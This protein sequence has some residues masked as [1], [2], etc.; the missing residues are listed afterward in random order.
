MSATGPITA[1]S[2]PTVGRLSAIGV[3]PAWDAQ[4]R[5]GRRHPAALL[6]L[7]R[8]PRSCRALIPDLTGGL[9]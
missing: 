6:P 1:A 7:A 2:Q 9:T 3:R 8:L 4:R 5:P